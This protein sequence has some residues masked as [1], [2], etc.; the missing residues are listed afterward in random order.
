MYY[1]EKELPCSLD[2]LISIV[3]ENSFALDTRKHGQ[4]KGKDVITDRSNTE[5]KRSTV[6][7]ISEVHPKTF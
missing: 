2:S 1:L 4:E 7:S 5:R 3:L 6:Y